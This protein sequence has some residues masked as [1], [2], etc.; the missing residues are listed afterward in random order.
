MWLEASLCL[1]DGHTVGSAESF[2][3]QLCPLSLFGAH[4]TPHNKFRVP[5]MLFRAQRIAAVGLSCTQQHL[6]QAGGMRNRKLLTAEV[7]HPGYHVLGTADLAQRCSKRRRYAVR[8]PEQ[9]PG[10]PRV[11]TNQVHANARKH[12]TRLHRLANVQF[13]GAS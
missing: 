9:Q 10:G 12:Q 7:G 2:Y 11:A 8:K 6:L 4:R 3:D 5:R 1:G 13:D